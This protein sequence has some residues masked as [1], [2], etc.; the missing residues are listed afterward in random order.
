[1]R[2]EN[3]YSHA[4]HGTPNIYLVPIGYLTACGSNSHLSRTIKVGDMRCSYLLNAAQQL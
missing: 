4:I 1:M 2:V 3:I